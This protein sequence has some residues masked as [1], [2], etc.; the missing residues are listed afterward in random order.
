MANTKTAKENIV[1]NERNRQRNLLVR[2]GMRTRIKQAREAINAGAE[3]CE[4]IVKLALV[5]IDKSVSKGVS[6]KN[7]AARNK[8]RLV[9]LLNKGGSTTA[10][11]TPS[12]GKKTTKETKVTTKAA[13]K[14]ATKSTSKATA[15]KATASSK[16]TTKTK[17]AT[18]ASKSKTE[19]PSKD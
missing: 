13:T 8:S 2:S 15:T 4:S 6:H 10:A 3:N 18:S 16:S 1:I 11:K 14:A 12:K 7:Y 17:A 9:T 19:T 5:T